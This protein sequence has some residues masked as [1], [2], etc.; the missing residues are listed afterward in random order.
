MNKTSTRIKARSVLLAPLL[1][2]AANLSAQKPV[3]VSPDKSRVIAIEG[4]PVVIPVPDGFS[5]D[6][7]KVRLDAL[8]S[9]ANKT[10]RER[11]YA[12]FAKG[13]DQIHAAMDSTAVPSTYSVRAYAAAKNQPVTPAAFDTVKF[14]LMN[15]WVDNWNR[16]NQGQPPVKIFDLAANGHMETKLVNKFVNLHVISMTDDS[17]AMAGLVHGVNYHSVHGDETANQFDALGVL[18]IKNRVISVSAV[19]LVKDDGD[20]E[21]QRKTVAA[22]MLHILQANAPLDTKIHQ[23]PLPTPPPQRLPSAAAPL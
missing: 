5:F 8:Q 19:A 4:N 20:I 13:D 9:A 22:W 2:I 17:I 1:L 16:A 11:I 12:I 3:A 6:D 7:S 10:T 14:Q 23:L 18:R 21:R 15:D